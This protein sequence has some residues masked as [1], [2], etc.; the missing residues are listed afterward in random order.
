M[1]IG[2]FNTL[3]A[4]RQTDNGFYLVDDALESVL[5]PNAYVPID[6]QLN[7]EINVFV[8][9]DSENR[10]IAT[11]LKPF[12]TV[13]QFASLT[14]KETTNFGAFLDWGL[15]KDLLLPF[16]ET[17]KDVEPGQTILVY[18]YLDLVSNQLVASTKLNKFI[19]LAVKPELAINDEVELLVWDF[20]SLGTKVIVN[21]QYSGLLYAQ[22]IF[23]EMK[24]GDALKGFVRKIRDDNK[25]DIAL[26][27][28][29][30]ENTTST[31]FDLLDYLDKNNGFLP[32]TDKST[33][34]EIAE[35]L[36][37]SKKTFK[38]SVGML[39]K[40]REIEIEPKGIRLLKLR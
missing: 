24:I 5:L 25:L 18:V 33:P 15:A 9:N 27:R 10:I 32:L 7:D 13:G 26:Q 31:A 30:L 11:T 36:G 39:Y 2:E 14:V 28:T 12:A 37:I 8:Y 40:N 3:T 22:E 35:K 23:T 21:G 6:L 19:D 20:T 34:E 38:K 29:G 17:D 16:R 1:K 4:N